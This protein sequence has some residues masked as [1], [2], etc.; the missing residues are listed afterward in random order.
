LRYRQGQ[1]GRGTDEARYQA[2]NP[3]PPG[4]GQ[5]QAYIQLDTV[6]SRRW[7]YPLPDFSS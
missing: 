6:D 3:G 4:A 5:P 2:F 7:S 1:V